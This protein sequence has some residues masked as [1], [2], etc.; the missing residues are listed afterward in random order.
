MTI[1]NIALGND[2][3][4]PALEITLLSSLEFKQDCL[5]IL[6]GAKRHDCVLDHTS[7]TTGR[8]TVLHSTITLAKKGDRLTFKYPE[9]GF[10]TYL[11]YCPCNEKKLTS[12]QKSRL[13]KSLPGYH[14]IRTF[15]SES[16]TI[17]ITKGPEYSSLNHVSTFLNMTWQTS[18]DMNDMG[19]RLCPT[20]ETDLKATP[21]EIISSPV[22]DGTIQFTPKGPIIVLRTRQTIGG[23]P[24]IF[25]VVDVDIDRLAQYAPHQIIRFEEITINNAR[26]LLLQKA[27]DIRN[28]KQTFLT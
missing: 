7:S 28:L 22:N 16:N 21:M 3:F 8:S 11:C 6:T 15:E 26:R 1:G 9:Y 23:Y 25:N 13:G 17:R 4:S 18:T 12:T 5:F 27:D 19:I 14:H 2:D 20:S 24:R 10:R